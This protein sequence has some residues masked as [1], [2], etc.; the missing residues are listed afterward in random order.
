MEILL[1]TT[2]LP[3]CWP[4]YCFSFSGFNC[5]FLWVLGK[6]MVS[7]WLEIWCDEMLFGP[8]S[9]DRNLIV[10]D[11]LK[12][13]DDI[14]PFLHPNKQI[15]LSSITLRPNLSD[16]LIFA[17]IEDVNFSTNHCLHHIRSKSVSLSW[18]RRIWKP[19]IPFNISVFLWKLLHQLF[20]II[21]GSAWKVGALVP[22]YQYT[23]TEA[24]GMEVGRLNY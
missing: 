16:R 24:E 5:Y 10:M 6:G 1:Q 18:T 9:W 11:S 4:L 2:L 12:Q 8:S 23:C 21:R 22:R 13:L 15:M 19:Y 3:Y 20:R 14:I 17:L 7:F